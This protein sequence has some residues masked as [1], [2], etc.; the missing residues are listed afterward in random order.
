[1][2]NNIEAPLHWIGRTQAAAMLERSLEVV[3]RLCRKGVLRTSRFYTGQAVCL[4]DVEAELR[5]RESDPREQRATARRRHALERLNANPP[6]AKSVHATV[7][8][9]KEGAK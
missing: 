7:Q 6:G 1:M 9:G 5:R 2:K 4:E 8:P 3:I